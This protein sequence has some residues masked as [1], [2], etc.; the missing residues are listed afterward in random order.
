M[1]ACRTEAASCSAALVSAGELLAQAGRDVTHAEAGTAYAVSGL[2][3]P[4]LAQA[5]G[6]EVG[7]LQQRPHGLLGPGRLLGGHRELAPRLVLG[8]GRDLLGPGAGRGQHLLGRL[9]HLVG[10]GVGGLARRAG[11]LLGLLAQRGGLGLCGRQQR[12]AA[13][14]CL[15]DPG[16][17]EVAGLGVLLVGAG[18]GRRH[19]RVR[20]LLR[21]R[22]H[23]VGLDVRLVL[24][25]LGGLEP[26]GGR[27]LGLGD[28]LVVVRL[29]RL[30]QEPGLVTGVADDLL[31][32]RGAVVEGLLREIAG[33]GGFGVEL[34]GLLAQALGLLGECASLLLGLGLQLLGDPLGMTKQRCSL[35]GPGGVRGV[36]SGWPCIATT[37]RS[38]QRIARTGGK[39]RTLSRRTG[40]RSHAAAPAPGWVGAGACPDG[41]TRREEQG[42][43]RAPRR[44]GL[45]VGGW[46]NRKAHQG[47][48]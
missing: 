35:V 46:T 20:L 44:P 24:A 2:A 9:S 41:L 30:H 13:R 33:P 29:R 19:P 39:W 45:S 6:L 15:G 11:L 10:V 32:V 3:M 26:L 12:L 16:R 43:T 8:R 17:D 7:R 36:G 48:W 34:V 40:P 37:C 27:A 28:D 1:A 4:E 22:A 14:L 21:L 23:P 47:S 42:V 5:V 38:S 31:G 25:L 18:P